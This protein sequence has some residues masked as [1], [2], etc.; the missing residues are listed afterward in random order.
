MEATYREAASPLVPSGRKLQDDMDNISVPKA[1]SPKKSESTRENSLKVRFADKP[2]NPKMEGKTTRAG[3]TYVTR[4]V[5]LAG[6]VYQMTLTKALVSEA[7][8]AAREAAK[9]ELKQLVDLK[10]WVY[11]KRPTDATPSVH[12]RETPCSMFLKAKFDARGKFL[13]WKARLVNGGHMTDPRRYDPFEKTSPTINLEVVMSQLAIAVTEKWQVE[14]F[15]VPGAYLNSTLKPE[16]YHKMRISGK[17]AQLLTEVDPIA[18]QAMNPDRTILVEIRRSLY[19]LPE[20]AQLWYDY[21]SNA[22]LDGGYQKCNVEPCL[23]RKMRRVNGRMVYSIVSVY[24]DDCLHIYNDTRIRD[25]LYANLR[26]AKLKD[27]KISQLSVGNDISFLG[28]NIAVKKEPNLAFHVDQSGY[29]DTLLE[30]YE[31]E[32]EGVREARTPCDENVF[33]PTD[34]EEDLELINITEF[35]S[36]LMRVRYLVRT[37]PDIELA[38]SALTT[39]SRSPCKGDM[40]RLNRVLSYLKH[41][42]EIGLILRPVKRVQIA[43]WTDAGFAVHLQRESHTGIIITL[44]EFGPPLYWKSLKQKLVTISST[45]A[46]LLAIFEAL[47]TLIYLR[48]VF[49]FLGFKQETTMLYQDNTSTITM[50]HMGRGSSGTK[51]RHIDNKYFFIKQFLE[52]KTFSIKH[53]PRENMIADFFASPRIGQGFRRMRDII[54]GRAE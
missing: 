13:L 24:V 2:V 46:E 19:G 36:K 22:L 6:K 41:T 39:K 29:L 27:L 45:E 15:D 33:R 3:K 40:K 17:I 5:K 49:D 16:R 4:Q 47:D 18:R 50:A 34:S 52:D 12:T 37:R 11:L 8:D 53:M 9:K 1:T 10:T 14:S 28:L 32:L 48:R 54:M 43:G 26:D 42:K 35:M 23:F 44:D 7:S 20:A 30:M 51:T 21:L 38:I 25:E 31:E